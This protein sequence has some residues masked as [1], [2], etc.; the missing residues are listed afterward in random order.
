MANEKEIVIR[1]LIKN[2]VKYVIADDN[3]FRTILRNLISNAIKFT[4]PKGEVEI[5][6]S[7]IELE[8]ILYMFL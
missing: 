5:L 6:F 2:K 7:D 8:R 3:M 1:R 4:N